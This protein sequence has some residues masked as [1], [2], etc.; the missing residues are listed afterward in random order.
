MRTIGVTREDTGVE[1][2]EEDSFRTHLRASPMARTD[3]IPIG[4]KGKLAVMAS[5]RGSDF[6]AIVEASEKGEVSYE[7]SL[8]I[9]NNPSAFV[10]ERAK[11]HSI[12]YVIVDHRGKD[13]TE[14]DGEIDD[15]LR[16]TGVDLVALAGFMRILSPEFVKRWED[17]IINI[18]P[19]L[20]P[21]FPGAHAH[22]DAI[23]YGV[24]VSGLTIHFVDEKTDHG[25]IIFQYPVNVRADDTEETLSLRILEKEHYWYP[26]IIDMVMKG[27]VKRVGRKVEILE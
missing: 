10:I 22:R 13:R 5:G 3:S 20:L 26:R 25:P 19:S 12:P 11:Q 18:H 7:V 8:L 16:E 14:F 1:A 17:R 23:D 6:E 15:V 9:C 24:K 2:G 4:K 21:S 27:R